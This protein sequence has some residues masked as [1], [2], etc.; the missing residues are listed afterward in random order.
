MLI[1]WS[2]YAQLLLVQHPVYQ[3]TSVLPLNMGPF[4]PGLLNS[5]TSTTKH[6]LS[7]LFKFTTRFANVTANALHLAVAIAQMQ[8]SF[9]I[10]TFIC[11]AVSKIWKDPAMKVP[12]IANGTRVQC[13]KTMR[14]GE[15]TSKWAPPIKINH[16]MSL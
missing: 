16:I 9:C 1:T 12:R 5:A 4:K 10:K 2:K 13:F 15:A 3:I 7:L 8:Q 11:F 14:F 6:S